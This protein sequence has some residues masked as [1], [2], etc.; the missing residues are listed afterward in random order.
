MPAKIQ[1]DVV[2]QPNGHLLISC[3][4]CGS[5]GINHQ[6]AKARVSTPQNDAALQVHQQRV[7]AKWASYDFQRKALAKLAKT[8]PAVKDEILALDKKLEAD[9]K[10]LTAAAPEDTSFTRVE[11][12]PWCKAPLGINVKELPA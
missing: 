10:E 11:T 4:K 9:I 5:V 7:E 2:R 12:C 6:V 1:N 3:E 8:N